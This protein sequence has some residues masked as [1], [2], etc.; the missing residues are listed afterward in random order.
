MGNKQVI[1][2]CFVISDLLSTTPRAYRAIRSLLEEGYSV[3]LSC[4]LR[5]V[6]AIPYHRELIKSLEKYKFSYSELSWKNTQI[7]TFLYKVIHK[8]T[9]KIHSKTS[10]KNKYLLQYAN[11]FTILKQYKSCKNIK[12]KVYVG[13]RP[14][15]LP[16]IT[17]LAAKHKAKVWFDIED[18]HF[19]ETTDPN[20]NRMMKEFIT[21]F[22]QTKIHYTN[23]SELIGKEYLHQLNIT[24]KSI[25]ILNSPII[26]NLNETFSNNELSFV[27]FSQTVT[28]KRGLEVFLEAIKKTKLKCRIDLIGSIDANFKEYIDKLDIKAHANIILHGFIPEDEINN[29]I[30]QADIGLALELKT[31]DKSRNFAITNKILSYSLLGNF[32]LASN[33][34]GQVSF[35]ERLL[36]KESYII[37]YK[38]DDF[39][40]N[41]IYIHEELNKIRNNKKKRLLSNNKFLWDNEKIKLL[42]FSTKLIG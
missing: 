26:N 16:I 9:K 38:Q 14:A 12:A 17:K 18:F 40:N 24:E 28:F 8:I 1:D 33:T 36:D 39:I 32:I 30:S 5:R 6:A 4:N 34:E 3:H 10:F 2:F 21:A 15:S 19:E 29:I 25:E 11:D 42:H 27:W 41:L 37:N 13:H 22:S 35:F 23:A 20:E 7:N 31:V